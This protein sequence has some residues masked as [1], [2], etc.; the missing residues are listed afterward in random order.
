MAIIDVRFKLEAAAHKPLL[1]T[2]LPTA[3]CN[4]LSCGTDASKLSATNPGDF[5]LHWIP[6]DPDDITPYDFF[7]RLESSKLPERDEKGIKIGQEIKQAL[8]G[9][10]SN[11]IFGLWCPTVGSDGL[12]YPFKT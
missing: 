9:K 4:A 8:L 1:S 5:E 11:L 10:V 2:L 6:G 7:I 12:W 3:V